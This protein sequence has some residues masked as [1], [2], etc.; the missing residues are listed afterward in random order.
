MIVLLI[1]ALLLTAVSA[2]GFAHALARGAW[3]GVVIFLT[4]FAFASLIA[5]AL[6][7]EVVV[8]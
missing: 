5:A 6:T 3:S 4:A 8:P 2:Y 7:R 1:V